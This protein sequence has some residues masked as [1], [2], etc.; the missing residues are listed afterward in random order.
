MIKV[1][2]AHRNYFDTYDDVPKLCELR[3]KYEELEE[4]GK[5]LFCLYG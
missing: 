5:K 2:C 4:E 3:D 1:A